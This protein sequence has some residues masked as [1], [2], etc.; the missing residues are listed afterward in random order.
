MRLSPVTAS[1]WLIT[2]ILGL[3][4]L[5]ELSGLSIYCIAFMLALQIGTGSYLS[6]LKALKFSLPFTLP[7]VIVHGVINPSFT[8]GWQ[9][10]LF[11]VRPDGL[12]YAAE[13]T[14]R[15]IILSLA[16]VS[17]RE[18]DPEA[19]LQDAIRARL[20]L[21]LIVAVAVAQSTANLLDRRI[22][23]VHLAQQARGVRTG[24]GL[25]ERISA[26]AALVVPVV[27]TTI[28]ENAERGELLATRGLG[29]RQ[30]VAKPRATKIEPREITLGLLPMMFPLLQWL[31]L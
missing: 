23:S 27:S 28:I 19:L 21:H 17:W 12:S 16:A 5:N 1:L 2:A 13:I 20:P 31:A 26:V 6:T 18:V 15:V 30:M 8:I 4:F 9:Y 7:L 24:P 22:H 25:T 10:W 14:L 3:I 11:S 29:G